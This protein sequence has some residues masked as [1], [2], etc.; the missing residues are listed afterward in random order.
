ME[1][2]SI[3]NRAKKKYLRVTFPNGKTF[4]YN[5]ATT[6]LIAVLREIGSERFPQIKLDVCYLPMLSKEVYPRLKDYMKPVCDG[7]YVNIQ[8]DTGGKYLQLRS[9]NDQLNLGLKIEIGEDLET[10]VPPDKEPKRRGQDKL[11][12]RFPDGEFVANDSSTDTFLECI[13]KLGVEEIKRKDISWGGNA[14]ISFRPTP[15]NQTQVDSDR[16]IIVP[17]ATKDKAKLLR[18]ISAMLHMKLEISII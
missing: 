4:C 9:I 8:S 12:V 11:L 7:W 6:T 15:R 5:N 10:E 14:L 16:W 18:V 2:K 1:D 3:K 17:N 13:W